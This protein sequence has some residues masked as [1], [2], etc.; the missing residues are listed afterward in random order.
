VKTQLK[1][2][3][4][5]LKKNS[6][7]RSETF[8]HLQQFGTAV[9]LLTGAR[10]ANPKL[11]RLISQATLLYTASLAAKG[12]YEI[13]RKNSQIEKPLPIERRFFVRI[14]RNEAMYRHVHTMVHSSMVK[15]PQGH[16]G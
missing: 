13:I 10:Y 3:A 14:Y 2:V 5:N 16:T 6:E 7:D 11:E 12:L 8:Q 1:A 4:L 15:V 9:S